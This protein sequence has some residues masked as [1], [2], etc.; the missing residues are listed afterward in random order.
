MATREQIG[1]QTSSIRSLIL[2]DRG[3]LPGACE[4]SKQLARALGGQ[5]YILET[6]SKFGI[7]HK[8]TVS[9]IE[10]TRRELVIDI[11][12]ENP[13]IG[14]ISDVFN[15]NQTAQEITDI[16]GLG[17]WRIMLNYSD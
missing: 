15:Y 1:S 3:S 10:K 8:V 5:V 14:I 12:L 2:S 16:Y 7:D 13:N 11:T 4:Y 17:D 9:R 6:P